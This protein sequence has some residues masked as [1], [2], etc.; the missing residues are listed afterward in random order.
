M[1]WLDSARYRWRQF[2]SAV[3]ARLTPEDRRWVD[4]R[5][6]APERELFYRMPRFD[7]THCVLVARDVEQ[8]GG[9]DLVV[10]ASLLH[11]CGKTLPPHCVPL[12]WRGL[13]VVLT[14]LAPHLL[15]S[16]AKPRGPLWPFYLHTHHPRLGA[17]ELERRGSPPD[18]VALVEYH[19][20]SS[21]DP[22]LRRLQLADGAN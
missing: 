8:A 22:R 21:D 18:L 3:D 17:R 12:L 19:Q 11:D 20:V 6:P 9:D 10:R 7:Q 13:V 2:R 16:L 14:R 5:L 1:P 15:S 4:A